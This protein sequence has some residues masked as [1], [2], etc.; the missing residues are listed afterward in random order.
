MRVTYGDT[1]V[2]L[3]FS[4]GEQQNDSFQRIPRNLNEFSF[5]PDRC[6][7]TVRQKQKYWQY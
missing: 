6:K 2:F 5:L 1:A 7:L 3:F 4:A